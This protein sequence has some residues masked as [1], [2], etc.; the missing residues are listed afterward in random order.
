MSRQV[1]LVELGLLLGAVLLFYFF[2]IPAGIID[3]DGFVLDEGL[4]PSFSA[5]LVAVLAGIILLGRSGRL[6]FGPLFT[7]Q[8]AAKP[9]TGDTADSLPDLA[10][11]NN[12]PVHLTQRVWVGVVVSLLF[13]FGLVPVLGFGA[14]SLIT[15][16]VMLFVLG[17]RSLPRLVIFP[18]L[19]SAGVWLLFTKILSV[20]LPPG[21]LIPLITGS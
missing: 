9:P 16:S 8:P 6:L 5:R 4:P 19:V 13:A 15:L 14:A 11:D 1:E 21:L 20:N 12:Q 2:V 3:P 10:D 18:V 17:E 7:Q